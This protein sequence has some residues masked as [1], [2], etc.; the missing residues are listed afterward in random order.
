MTTF[1]IG[2]RIVVV[3]NTSSGKTT[4]AGRLAG[5]LG[6]PHVELDALYW[7]PGWTPVPK[8]L[9]RQRVAAALAGDRWVVDGNYSKARDI[10]WSRADTVIWLDFPLALIMWRLLRRTVRRVA[11]REALWNSNR[12]SFR[13]AF[14]S[15]DSLFLWAL[16]THRRKRRDYTALLSDGGEYSHLNVVRLCSPRAVEQWL[17]NWNV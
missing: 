13:R 3:G 16:R 1:V 15:R 11:T 7:D 6:Y 2:S 5:R 8:E 17:E 4:L 12:E 10:S 9:F 14:M